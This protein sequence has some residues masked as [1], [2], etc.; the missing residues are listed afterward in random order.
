MR[1]RCSR[2]ERVVAR[3]R[4]RARE[5]PVVLAAVVVLSGGRRVG[6]RAGR[7]EVLAPDLLGGLAQFGGHAVHEPL[8]I[9][10]GLRPS[11]AA[12]GGDR[13]RVGED[14]R[15]GEV[16]VL[17]A[18]DAH[19]HHQREIRDEREDGI[20]AEIRHHAHAERRDA[21]VGVHRRLHVGRVRPPVSGR[22][23]V[24][25]ARLD[26]PER[27]APQPGQ[28]RNRDIFRIGAELHPE[29]A[30]DLRRD[31]A[32]LVLG[33]PERVRQPAAEHVRRLVT[34]PHHEPAGRG[35]GGGEDGARL[36]RDPRETLAV[37]ALLDHAMGFREGGVGVAG[38]DGL[39]MLNVLGRVVEELRRAVGHG[40]RG[41]RDRRQRLPVHLDQG[42]AIRGGLD[43]RAD[44]GGHGFSHVA[45]AI[46]GQRI[47]LA[48][49]LGLA[50]AAAFGGDGGGRQRGRMRHEIAPGHHGHDARLSLGRG[51]IDPADARVGVGAPDEDDVLETG[52]RDVG[53]V[54][55]RARDQAR[56]LLAFDLGSQELTCHGAIVLL[57]RT[58]RAAGRLGVDHTASAPSMLAWFCARAGRSGPRPRHRHR[59]TDAHAPVSDDDDSPVRDRLRQPC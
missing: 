47:V 54:L 49:D 10:G 57:A 19:A 31:D 33:H 18:I 26:P 38:L 11:R 3:H 24:L 12:I 17:D 34:G 1:A 45:H 58:R 28:R 42:G 6:E 21:A 39:A 51:A 16:H 43:R 52:Q 46:D 5:R 50:L 8:Q 55:R 4:E 25:G 15:V 36:H 53:D 48:P 44:D 7:D 41:V 30:A 59:F 27:D 22:R 14:A 56:I 20:G 40:S 9:V 32:D 2:A 35:I 37:H 23:H 29:A 13:R